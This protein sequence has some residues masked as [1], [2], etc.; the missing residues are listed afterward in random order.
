[1]ST[2]PRQSTGNGNY[3][4]APTVK[5]AKVGLSNTAEELVYVDENGDNHYGIE[6]IFKT[7]LKTFGLNLYYDSSNAKDNYDAI[8]HWRNSFVSYL[9]FDINPED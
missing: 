6:N 2:I 8:G 3:Y 7:E 1:M 4:L 9:D 5:F